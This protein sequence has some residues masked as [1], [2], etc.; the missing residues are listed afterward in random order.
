[1]GLLKC[2]SEE[3]RLW[4]SGGLFS[5]ESV[6]GS[7]EMRSGRYFFVILVHFIYLIIIFII[8]FCNIKSI[9]FAKLYE[10]ATYIFVLLCC[11]VSNE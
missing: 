9:K 4:G 1:M 2:E 3:A 8:Y 7:R 11:I 5:W 6:G 10:W